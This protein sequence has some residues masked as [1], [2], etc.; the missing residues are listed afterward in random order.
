MAHSGLLQGEHEASVLG[1]VSVFVVSQPGPCVFRALCP[2][3][4]EMS[5]SSCPFSV[6]LSALSPGCLQACCLKVKSHSQCLGNLPRP[7]FCCS[8]LNHLAESLEPLCRSLDAGED[9]VTSAGKL[10]KGL[11]SWKRAEPLL[12]GGRREPELLFSK[13]KKAVDQYSVLSLSLPDVAG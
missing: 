13:P 12:P 6:C 8:S 5:L 3:G 9:L 2:L 7:A 4:W 1:R 10:P 11:A